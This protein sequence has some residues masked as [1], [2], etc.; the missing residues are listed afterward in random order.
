MNALKQITAVT[1]MELKNIPS[2]LGASFV[3]IVS[4]AC[5]VGAVVIVITLLVIWG[6]EHRGIAMAESQRQPATA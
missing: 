5:V 4:M 2:R 1:L 3:V 6:P